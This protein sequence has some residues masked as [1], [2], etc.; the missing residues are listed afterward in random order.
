[1]FW[2]WEQTSESTGLGI[3]VGKCSRTV[4]VVVV[5]QVDRRG[6]YTWLSSKQRGS[7]LRL[8][9]CVCRFTYHLVRMSCSTSGSGSNTVVCL[10]R[11]DGT[12]M[13]L[14]GLPPVTE[15]INNSRYGIASQ[16]WEVFQVDAIK[17]AGFHPGKLC[18]RWRLKG[19]RLNNVFS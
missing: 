11:K 9:V 13:T 4:V 19:C 2:F 5:V 7:R 18:R 17:R 8:C 16:P 12:K 3:R 6:Y 1:M 14:V 10:P 15:R